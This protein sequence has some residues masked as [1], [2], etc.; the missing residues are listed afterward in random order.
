M[1][2]VWSDFWPNQESAALT[3][4][5]IVN[6]Q[7]YIEQRIVKNKQIQQNVLN[8]PLFKTQAWLQFNQVGFPFFSASIETTSA[9]PGWPY[10]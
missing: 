5:L 7:N 6:E 10:P 1:I 9:T 8:T 3:I 2:P 4:A